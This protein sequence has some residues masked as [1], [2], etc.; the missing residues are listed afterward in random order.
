MRVGSDRVTEPDPFA[1]RLDQVVG[2]AFLDQRRGSGDAGLP[3]DGE[4]PGDHPVGDLIDIYVVEEDVR[5]LAAQ[6][7][8]GRRTTRVCCT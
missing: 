3:S 1:E 4:D 5:R 8:H 7:Q 2:D 6:L